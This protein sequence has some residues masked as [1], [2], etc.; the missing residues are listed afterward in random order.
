MNPPEYCLLWIDWWPLCMTKAE[1]SGWC[2]V[3]VSAL[4][5]VAGFMWVRQQH[6]LGR[7]A[8][9]D[10]DQKAELKEFDRLIDA[11]AEPVRLLEAGI[12]RWRTGQPLDREDYA[13][14]H[15]ALEIVTAMTAPTS[16]S[17]AVQQEW[18]AVK[19]AAQQALRDAE[20]VYVTQVHVRSPEGQSYLARAE[21]SL[22]RLQRMADSLRQVRA[23]VHR[24]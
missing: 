23:S 5:L 12:M 4:A 1:W 15:R 2:Q 14:T 7:E 18:L 8:R 3:A 21:R 11:I 6:A 22:E 9:R 10:D 20:S 24:L 17:A 19:S 13:R 16:L